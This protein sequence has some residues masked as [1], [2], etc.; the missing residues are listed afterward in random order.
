MSSP[1]LATSSQDGDSMT[2]RD[3]SDTMSHGSEDSDVT[4]FEESGVPNLDEMTTEQKIDILVTKIFE[5]DTKLNERM[6][7][8]E[9]RTA[10][11]ESKI[12]KIEEKVGN[13]VTRMDKLNK[14]VEDQSNRMRRN[15]VIFYGVPEEAEGD[16]YGSCEAFVRSLIVDH[17]GMYDRNNW[18]IERAH[19]SPTGPPLASGAVRPIVVKFLRYQNRVDL[20]RQAPKKL[21]DNEFQSAKI[22]VSDDVTFAVRQDRKKLVALKKMVKEKFPRRKVFIPPSVPA[23]LLRENS[24]GKLV[25]VALGTNLSTLD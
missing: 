8:T 9:K 14:I 16:G 22:Y 24:A 23:V 3:P 2:V 10:A 19:R 15:N 11:V 12:V 6:N 18:E 4:V 1:L 21:K 25:R 17:M 13:V 7:K 5:M 20:L